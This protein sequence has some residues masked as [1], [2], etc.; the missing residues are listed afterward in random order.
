MMA[1]VLLQ[2]Q[3][4]NYAKDGRFAHFPILSDSLVEVNQ[5]IKAWSF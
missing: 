4:G 1:I 2:W 5:A 3:E